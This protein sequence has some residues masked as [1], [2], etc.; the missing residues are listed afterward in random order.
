MEITNLDKDVFVVS[1]YDE[2]YLPYTAPTG[3]ANTNTTAADGTNDPST[4]D[5][6]GVIGISGSADEKTVI[7]EYTATGSGLNY[8][9]FSKTVSVP[10]SLI[11]GGGSPIKVT[12]S[13]P[14]GSTSGTSG[15]ITATIAAAS[16]LNAKKLDINSGIG[17]ASS[18]G[19]L[20]AVFNGIPIDDAGST[21]TV[22]LRDL[23]GIPDREYGDGDHDFIYLPVVA[24]D[25]KTWLNNNL[26]AGYANANHTSFNLT[27]QATAYNDLNA[28]GSLFQWG[29][30]SD[31]HELITWKS[32]TKGTA[33]YGTTSTN[34]STDDPGHSDFILEPY[35]PMDWRAPRND[36]LWQGVNGINNPCPVGYRLPTQA[37]LQ[38]W[39]VAAGINN[40]V[41]AANSDLALSASGYRN[42]SNGG[43]GSASTL[44][45][46]WTS[47][48]SGSSAYRLDIKSTS[49]SWLTDRR[50]NAFACRCIKD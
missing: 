49:T 37:E 45:I 12:F 29:R 13:F 24:E 5:V 33:V 46:Y 30:Y 48:P 20:M 14:A 35:S 47:T 2:D 18:L 15:T 26:G 32:P 42:R 3:P 28:Y 9:G 17:N 41:A 34:S 44:G 8:E 40:S 25:G 38:A 36:N 7:L 21:G 6:Q 39:L 16:T 19:V 10:A 22:T 31:G 27:K 50:A 4:A 23:P 1:V 43:F 11:E